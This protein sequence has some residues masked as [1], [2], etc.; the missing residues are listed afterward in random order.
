MKADLHIHTTYSDGKFTVEE[1]I[2]LAISRN[3]DLISI[4]DHD[5]FEGV[6]TAL[7]MKKDLRIIIGIELSTIRNGENVHILGY[8]KNQDK[9]DE[10]QPILD[11]QIVRRHERAYK[12]LE[13]LK[14]H[15][16][17]DLDPSFIKETESVTRGT[18]A[19][20]IIKQ[21]Y[22][23]TN[24]IIF[25]YMIGE[26]CPAYIPS[27]KIETEIGIKMIKECGGLAVLA[28]PMHLEH[29]DPQDI[30]NYGLDG[31][32]AIYPFKEDQEEKYRKLAEKNNIF[33]TAGSDFHDFND[34]RH[35]N[36]GDKYLIGDDLNKFLSVLY[37][38]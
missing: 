2:N 34:G 8:F 1:V 22:D 33:I 10:M 28:H 17:I 31:I 18:I 30:I 12:V 26:G 11:K 15:F 4:T 19:R 7:N 9:I 36:I 32:E 37:E 23:Y 13:K 38:S 35:G 14:E 27:S 24:R 16:N 25:K 21:G 3:L 20:E 5:T 29:N 6:K